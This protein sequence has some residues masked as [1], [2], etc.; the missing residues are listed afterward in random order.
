MA[1]ITLK[2]IENI[3]QV[4]KQFYFSE[5]T[6]SQAVDILVSSHKM[7]KNSMADYIYAFK[8]LM[9]GEEYTRTISYAG[10]KY[11]LENIL[12]D[13]G[14][15]KFEKAISSVKLH[16]KY[17]ENL[18]N[19]TMKKQRKLLEKLTNSE[20][21]NIVYPDEISKKEE[22]KILEGA[23]KQVLVNVYERDT[24]A[25]QAC[26]EEFGYICKICGFDFEKKYGLIGKEFIHVHHL[27]PL[28]EI[29]EEYEVNPIE[30]LIPVCPNCHAM[31]HRKIPAYKPEDIIDLLK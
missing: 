8:H 12:K 20:S 10:T 1:K 31:L 2:I 23:K 13:F 17:Y 16:I 3:Y 28:S 9:E 5:I 14:I 24:K 15:E 26:L 30:D 27:I 6:F 11:Y 4:S 18:Q 22:T 21:S 25:R 7:N 29:K 19:I